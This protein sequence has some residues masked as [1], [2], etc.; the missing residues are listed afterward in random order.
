MIS[1]G[2]EMRI[3]VDL[4]A[5]PSISPEECLPRVFSRRTGVIFKPRLNAARSVA[6]NYISRGA[7]DKSEVVPSADDEHFRQQCARRCFMRAKNNSLSAC[8]KAAFKV[9]T[10]FRAAKLFCAQLRD[11]N[12]SRRNIALFVRQIILARIAWHC[13]EPANI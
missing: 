4:A 13:I 1:D 8:F 3:N 11:C 7:L 10:E 5:T 12:V 9:A 2:A 6:A